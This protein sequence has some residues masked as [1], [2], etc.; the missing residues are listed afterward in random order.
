[1]IYRNFGVYIFT[2]GDVVALSN[3][4]R[5]LAIT[6][7]RRVAS[8]TVERDEQVVAFPTPEGVDSEGG[9]QVVGP[10]RPIYSGLR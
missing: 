10:F 6:T 5:I 2:T 1:M 3:D 8:T 9:K 7:A 4:A